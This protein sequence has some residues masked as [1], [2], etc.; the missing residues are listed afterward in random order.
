MKY[1]YSLS[2]L[3][4]CTLCSYAFAQDTHTEDVANTRVLVETNKGKFVLELFDDTPLHRDNFIRLVREGRYDGTLFHRVIKG[5]MIQG[6]NLLSKG[7]KYDDELPED[8]IAGTIVPEFLPEKYVHLRGMLAAAR[9]GDELNPDKRSSASQ[10]YIVT[11][12][13]YTELDLREESKKHGW[14]YKLDQLKAYMLEG[15]AAHLD[16]TYTIF[17]RVLE[18]YPTVDKIQRVETDENDR[19]TKN[20]VVKRMTILP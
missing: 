6:G 19:P 15:G 7:L 16:G 20:V 18:G 8:S 17:G 10:Y 9:Q 2:L 5:F 11:G 12:K 14:S 1:L 3:L 4:V 13:Y